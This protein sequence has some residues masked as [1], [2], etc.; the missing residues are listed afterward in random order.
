MT[1]RVIFG[2]LVCLSLASLL[3][4]QD[5]PDK[6]AAQVNGEK[7]YVREVE[8]E[9][10]RILG[11]RPTTDEARQTLRKETLKMLVNRQHAL[12]Y[13]AS[14]KLAA[15]EQDLDVA[16]R[17]I[18]KQLAEQ[19]I[20]L[21]QYLEKTEQS[22]QELRRLLRWRIS[23]RRFLERYATEQNLEKFFQQRKREFDGTKLRVSHLLLK[24]PAGA[25]PDAALAKAEKIRQEI[26][27]KKLDFA[28]A[29]R[30]HSQSPTAA[31]GGDI[32]WISR[33]H[34]MPEPFSQAA[35]TL[36]VNQVSSPVLTPFG[37]HLIQCREVQP[38]TKTWRDVRAPL[39]RAIA[40]Y[41]FEWAVTKGK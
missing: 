27:S 12:K 6:I 35:Y 4:A 9:L 13:M 16:V 33:R 11:D 38:G 40:A 15:T 22:T 36:Q 39:E 37:V 32:G 34:P 31:Q 1:G 7:I 24:T 14:Q 28:A 26:L 5:A 25:S 10:Q 2:S 8:R 18:E 17:R 19:E 3:P 23:W 20:S 30:Q 41:L 29:V 21:N